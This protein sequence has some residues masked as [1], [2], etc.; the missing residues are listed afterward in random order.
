MGVVDLKLNEVGVPVWLEINPQG[1]FLF[2]E[3]LS[4]VD[5]T[6]QLASFLAHEVREA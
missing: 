6:Q 5:L 1:Q 2:S 3:A 4:G